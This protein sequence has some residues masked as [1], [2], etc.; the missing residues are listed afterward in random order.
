MSKKVQQH[1]LLSTFLRTEFYIAYKI[2]IG[3]KDRVIT[4]YFNY[5]FMNTTV[6][7]TNDTHGLAYVKTGLAE[8]ME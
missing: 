3:I 7:F 2:P 6:G 5:K 8:S 4:K 1:S